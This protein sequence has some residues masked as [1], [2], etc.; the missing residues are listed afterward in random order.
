M[1]KETF[2]PTRFNHSSN[3]PFASVLEKNIS[4][5]EVLK[6]GGAMAALS[7][8]GSFALSVAVVA[9]MLRAAITL[10]QEI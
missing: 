3:E 1:S 9:V 2:D 4:R 5:R 7:M 6:T 10:V 8:F